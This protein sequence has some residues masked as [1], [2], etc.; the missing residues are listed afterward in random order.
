[1]DNSYQGPFGLDRLPSNFKT[2]YWA[3]CLILASKFAASGYYRVWF[4]NFIPVGDYFIWASI[5]SP[6]CVAV[7]AL[8]LGGVKWKYALLLFIFVPAIVFGNILAMAILYGL[9][10]D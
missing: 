10:G 8:R 7:A 9:M 3:V 1:M 6:I 2:L 5:I 4:T